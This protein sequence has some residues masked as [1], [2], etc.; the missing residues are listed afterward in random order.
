VV[1]E[2][3]NKMSIEKLK[4]GVLGFFIVL[5]FFIG[6]FKY[7]F[8]KAGT[9]ANPENSDYVGIPPFMVDQ[10][11][12]LPNLI[13]IFDNSSYMGRPAYCKPEGATEAQLND[14]NTVNAF[15]PN[16]KYVGL[17][18][19]NAY[20]VY[21]NPPGVGGKT[22]WRAVG[23]IKNEDG[24][25]NPKPEDIVS[26]RETLIYLPG[27]L[28]NWAVMSKWDVL[29]AVTV[30]G[31]VTNLGRGND[32]EATGES[33]VSWTAKANWTDPKTG[34]TYLYT[35][36]VSPQRGQNQ[37]TSFNV[38]VGG[39][40]TMKKPTTQFAKKVKDTNLTSKIID[41]INVSTAFAAQ[42]STPII[43]SFTPTT[44]PV[45]TQVTIYGSNFGNSQGKVE[46][47]DGFGVWI[48]ATISS[49]APNGKQIVCFVPVGA[50]TGPIKV[51]T[52]AD[53]STIS[54]SNFIVQ[55]LPV[56]T[57]ISPT[58]GFQGTQVTL[59]GT[60]F[61]SSGTITLEEG[62]NVYTVGVGD[63]FTYTDT[64]I[65]FKIPAGIPT[66][67]TYNVFVTNSNGKS[68]G[69][70]FTV[71]ATTTAP[72]IYK[73]VPASAYNGST[74]TINGIN[75]ATRVVDD[76]FVVFKNTRTNTEYTADSVTTWT[77]TQIVADVPST[78]PPGD[79]VV[80]V[81]RHKK[82]TPV[83]SN[84]YPFTIL[85]PATYGP[86]DVSVYTP[87][88][89]WGVIQ[90]LYMNDYDQAEPSWKEDVPIPGFI[91]FDGLVKCLGTSVTPSH[92]LNQMRKVNLRTTTP[93]EARP[94]WAI[95]AAIKYYKN[96][97]TLGCGDPL[98][99]TGWCRKNFILFVGSGKSDTGDLDKNT[100]LNSILTS[101][102][103][104]IRSDIQNVQT[105]TYYAVSVSER[106]PLRQNLKDV[107]SY[108]GFTDLNSNS[109]L[110][111]G[112]DKTKNKKDIN[113]N[114]IP[115]TYFEPIGDTGNDLGQQIK[116]AVSDIL[117][118]ATSGTAVSVL[119]T[120]AEGEGALFQAFFRPIHFEADHSVSWLGYLQGLFI[121]PYGN[122]RADTDGD[123]KLKLAIDDIVHLSFDSATG[124]TVAQLFRDQNGDGKPDTS[125]PY[126]TIPLADLPTLWEA[127]K[128]LAEMYPNDRNIF[129]TIDGTENGRLNFIPSNASALM[130]LLKAP[131]VDIAED[132]I[133]F[134]RGFDLSIKGYR[135]KR[136]TI[137]NAVR[138]WKLADI[139]YSTPTVVSVPSENYDLIYGDRS[140]FEF[141]NAYKNRK[142]VIY[143]GS[144]DGLL[145]AFSAGKFVQGDDGTGTTGYFIDPDN[146]MGKELW[147]F[148]PRSFLPH[149]QWQTDKNYK[150][151]FGIDL[152]VKVVD[153]QITKNG[154]KQWAT[155]LIGGMRLGG[156][157]IQVGTEVI[158]PSYFA[159]DVTDPDNPQI[160]WEFS[161]PDLG[162]TLSYPAVVKKGNKWYAIFGSGPFHDANDGNFE[163][164]L[165]HDANG[166]RAKSNRTAKFFI[167][168][169]DNKSA[170]QQNVNFWIKDTGIT[171]AFMGNPVS[172]DVDL[173]VDSTRGFES[174]VVYCGLVQGLYIT[175]QTGS[176]VRMLLNNDDPGQ[177]SIAKIFQ[178][179]GYRPLLYAPTVS[180]RGD[181][182][183]I[184]IASGRFLHML[185]RTLNINTQKL[186]GF[187]DP[188]YNGAIQSTCN[189][190]VTE[191]D[192]ADVSNVVVKI[193]GTVSGTG[194]S[195]NNATNF[196]ALKTAV[197]SKRGWMVNLTSMERGVAKPALIGDVVLF[198]TYI[199][200]TDVC[201]AGGSGYL[202]A[203]YSLTGTAY[204]K[205]IIGYNTSTN[206]I[207]KKMTMGTGTP[208]SISIHMGR[209]KGGRA[210]IQ[211]S[212]GA[213]MNVEFQTA[214]KAKSGYVLWMEKW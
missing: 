19:N 176:F 109:Q 184:Y 29:K 66:D 99:S 67:K 41:S 172:L 85:Q 133:N 209:E 3:V 153:V 55:I 76:D 130:N 69:I 28:L 104:D 199:P 122:I 185:D 39:A 127:G 10:D 159:L 5:T 151:I 212:T 40:I 164:S 117:K 144:N 53:A 178:T 18:D 1:W 71:L 157:P 181:D 16:Y 82:S 56:I 27:N 201:S 166:Y 9:L 17:F 63:I 105:I 38:K 134:I 214:A 102:T 142:A 202:Y 171:N 119:A 44:G 136:V 93:P 154:S 84:E 155:V 193:D 120:S 87:Y 196:D 65:T 163:N 33:N 58:Q 32:S 51:T 147:A 126:R 182:L 149:I 54:S 160:L 20:Y 34:I 175:Q 62:T 187:K 15:N 140:Y 45:G 64:S 143:V 101:H 97:A 47:S 174:D 210:Y 52:A 148:I 2:V 197:D 141:Y 183:W 7:T 81:I 139:V 208:S 158:Y 79:Y 83:K 213:I 189:T 68:N 179:S 31:N 123:K 111:T 50:R 80:Y 177:W 128:K 168:D 106:D 12:L 14:E 43:T 165:Y 23:P 204:I 60:D 124:D 211:Q 192:L 118:R 194:A 24:T 89:P 150:H 129:T 88:N 22:R 6:V 25:Y 115:D 48:K 113:N 13:V 161:H 135:D 30:G 108:G 70:P 188:C 107:S 145:H 200:T 35:F 156:G 131:S 37:P 57:S 73:I 96:T 190:V 170:W 203:L 59:T 146:D 91:T 195:T 11:Q 72:V 137:N 206:E 75:F 198:T 169:I 167:V 114:V 4:K 46:F 95:D 86:F 125:L 162:L 173:V 132:Y 180:I 207:Y 152:K 103:Q 78:A 110:D 90:E 21:Q 49:W 205:P 191:N 92:F 8:I 61:G 100:T 26:E 36:Y 77:N 94:F 186:Y 74:V 42:P 116:D 138:V 98:T 121:D 112:E